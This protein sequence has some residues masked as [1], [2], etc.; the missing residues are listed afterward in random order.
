MPLASRWAAAVLLCVACS[1]APARVRAPAPRLTSA[2]ATLPGDLDAT[3]WFD[4]TR[5]RTLWSYKPDLQ[6]ANLL[7][8]YGVMGSPR[9]P[10]DSAFWLHFLSRSDQLWVACRPSTTGCQDTVVYARGN[11]RKYEPRLALTGTEAPVDLGGGW[12]RYDRPGKRRR[13][14]PARIYLAPPDRCLVSP[15]A[16]LDSIERSLEQGVGEG[17]PVVEERGLFSIAVRTHAVA[18][19]M[20]HRA[21]AAARLMRTA[22]SIHL[23]L[24]AN[25]RDLEL[26]VVIAFDHRD[27][28]ERARLAFAL[29]AKAI[30]ILSDDSQQSAP[31]ELLDRDLVL[32]V[33][34]NASQRL[35]PSDAPKAPEPAAE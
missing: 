22:R 23:R 24:D 6:L 34:L 13:A 20:E 3:L 1:S 29:V 28:A 8:E 2:Q 18:E 12:F 19:L 31:I 4:L 15:V 33:R 14:E 10:E 17:A 32:R 9:D 5:L 11:F 30:G 21:P 25:E 16:E 27:E 35:P 26:I 7:R